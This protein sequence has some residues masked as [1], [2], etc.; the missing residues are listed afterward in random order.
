MVIMFYLAT[1][2]LVQDC[3]IIAGLHVNNR[4]Q[5]TSVLVQPKR[6]DIFTN[7]QCST[8]PPVSLSISLKGQMSDRCSS[9]G[10]Y[11]IVITVA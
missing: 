1:G 8:F 11:L 2:M 3:N 9:L 5:P 4:S 7:E 10:C 6:L